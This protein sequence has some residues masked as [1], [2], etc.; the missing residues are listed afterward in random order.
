[1]QSSVHTAMLLAMKRL[2]LFMICLLSVMDLMSTL[3]LFS[4]SSI[5]EVQIGLNISREV[6]LRINVRTVCYESVK[7]YF[8]DVCAA[9]VPHTRLHIIRRFT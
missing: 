3:K 8:Y 7:P 9:V 4:S 6:D 2:S 1:M 5:D